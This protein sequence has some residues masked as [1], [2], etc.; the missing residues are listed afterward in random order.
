[1]INEIFIPLAI[2][3][4]LGLLFALILTI[5]YKTLKV[6][7]DPKIGTVED[8]LPGA[9]CGACGV[10]GCHAF[11]EGVVEEGINPAKCTVNSEENIL[12]IADFLG[13]EASKEEK[14]IARLLCA[15]GKNNAHNLADYKGG[16]ST[17]RG[18]AVVAGGEKACTWGCLGLGDCETSCSFGAISMTEEGLPKVDATKCTACN[19]CVEICPKN[20]FKL[21]PV[22]QKL[23]VQCRSLLEGDLAL[24]KCNVA[25]TA[26][27]RC[28]ADSAPKLITIENNLA[29]INYDLNEL[30]DPVAVKRCPTDAIVWLEGE[31]QFEI[32]SQES[33]P[34]GRVEGGLSETY[35]Q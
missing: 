14:R 17:C 25:C 16:V 5:A 23:L 4:G 10:P 24:S 20:L 35:Y 2:L 31:Q 32:N 11:A 6:Y 29:V 30:A 33:L 22:S 27:S 12:K 3:T 34:L 8:L 26:C 7:E 1:M 28:V 13:V 18:E 9:N 19:D 21:M 15:G